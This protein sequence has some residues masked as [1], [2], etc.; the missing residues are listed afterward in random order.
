MHAAS[1]ALTMRNFVLFMC[2]TSIFSWFSL[3][4]LLMQ[5]DAVNVPHLRT[6]EMI[7]YTI[8]LFFKQLFPLR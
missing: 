3:D 1:A 4:F 5:K 8:V 7:Y 6:A 2:S